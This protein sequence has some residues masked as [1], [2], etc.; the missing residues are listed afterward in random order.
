[1][2]A[3]VTLWS[4]RGNDLTAQF[5]NIAKACEQLPPRTL[6]D[7]EIVAID[8]NSRKSRAARTITQVRGFLSKCRQ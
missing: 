4:R 8:E 7:G 5:P 1:D 2:G 6:L 3:G